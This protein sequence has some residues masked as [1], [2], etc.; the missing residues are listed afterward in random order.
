MNS[1]LDH[2]TAGGLLLL[3][4]LP[5]LLGHA[6]DRRTERALRRAERRDDDAGGGGGGAAGAGAAPPP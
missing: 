2:L 5:A 1:V 3:V 6:R 4:A